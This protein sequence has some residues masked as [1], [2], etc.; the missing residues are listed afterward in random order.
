MVDYK[1]VHGALDELATRLVIP[2]DMIQVHREASDRTRK[3]TSL[4]HGAFLLTYAPFE[5]FFNR[6]AEAHGGAS[7]GLAVNPDRIRFTLHQHTGITD[8]TAAWKARARVAPDAARST[9]ISPWIYIERAR[10]RD[11]LADAQRLRNLLAHGAAHLGDQ[12]RSGTLHVVRGGYSARLMW[13][14]GFLQAAQDLA[15]QTALTLTN[16]QASL[17]EWP[18]PQLSATSRSGLLERPY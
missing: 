15:A 2:A 1:A 8:A 7:R 16:G 18:S 9:N 10:L 11:Y 3:Y 6:L 13:V 17:P 4:R 12:N 5:R 14:E